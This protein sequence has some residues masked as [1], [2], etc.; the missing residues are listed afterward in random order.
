MHAMITRMLRARIVPEVLFAVVVFSGTLLGRESSAIPEVPPS[1]S[2]IVQRMLTHNEH[3]NQTLLEFEAQRKFFAVNMRFKMDSTMVVQTVFRRP[4]SM[5]SSVVSEAGSTL[6]KQ[7]VFD[8]ILKSEAE[9]HRKEDK[10]QVD[11]TPRNYN[12]S[13]VAQEMCND[14]PC[15]RLSISPKRKDKYSLQGDAW[16][17]AE[18]YAIVRLHG[19]PAKKPS[20]WTLKTEIDKRYRKIEAMWLP[21]RLD[22]SSDIFVAGH[23]TLSIEYVYRTVL[24]SP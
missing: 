12:F 7:R 15:Y 14:R 10:Q 20:F 5:E 8:E 16:I 3:Q 22:S 13:F 11:I 2:E 24:T 9:T 17:D 18:D 6:I 23:S 21:D 19:A 1:V 4:D